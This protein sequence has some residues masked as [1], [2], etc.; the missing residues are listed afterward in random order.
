MNITAGSTWSSPSSSAGSGNS[1]PQLWDMKWF[2]ILSVPLLFGT[3]IVPI[4]TGPVLRW[5]FRGYVKLKPFLRV[6]VIVL[7]LSVSLT[8]Y[9]WFSMNGLAGIYLAIVS[10]VIL[11]AL[12]LY[13][14]LRAFRTRQHEV[15]WLVYFVFTRLCGVVTLVYFSFAL[16]FVA[17]GLFPAIHFVI[18][19]REKIRGGEGNCMIGITESLGVSLLGAVLV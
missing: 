12:G 1:N 8:V 16:V 3:I 5:L 6:I 18:Y 10:S 14:T 4:I 7:A 2:T 19:S 15:I 17:L 13:Q 11:L 9:T